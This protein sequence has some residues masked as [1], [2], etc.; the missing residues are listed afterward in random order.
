ME[1]MKVSKINWSILDRPVIMP[2]KINNDFDI[3]RASAPCVISLKD[4]ILMYYWGTCEKGNVILAA[5]TTWE[6]LHLWNGFGYCL[7]APQQLEHNISGPSFPFV[8]QMDEKVWFMYFVAWGK[9]K[10]KKIPNTTCLA[11]SNDGGKR[12]SYYEKNP[13]IKLDK[14]WDKEGTGSVCVIKNG[15]D[16][17]MYYTCIGEYYHKPPGVKTGHG[18]IIPRIGIGMAFSKNGIDWEKYDGLIL[19]PRGFGAQPYEYIVSKPCVI[20]DGSFFR[21]WFSSF[22]EAYRIQ[23]AVSM[24]GINFEFTTTN[25]D[26]YF[27]IGKSPGFDDNQRSYAFVLKKDSTYHMWYA[28]NGF[29]RKG[30]GYACGSV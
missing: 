11:I 20:K 18:D 21:M 6:K 7:L 15:S 24:D 23:E 27:G 1:R 4:R 16:L 30:I 12:W 28:G 9:Q 13:I 14:P 22:G 17:W 3:Y 10:D 5:E 2:G 29:G 25:L 8:V 19:S 26:E